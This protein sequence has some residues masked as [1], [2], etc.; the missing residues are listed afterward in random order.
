MEWSSHCCIKTIR[1]MP[2]F[3]EGAFPR[4]GA[5]R[6]RRGR[7]RRLRQ[8]QR[9]HVTEGPLDS[10]PSDSDLDWVI[11][12]NL[13]DNAPFLGNPTSRISEAQRD[14]WQNEPKSIT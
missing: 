2:N 10:P 9:R 13:F 14:S 12:G 1:P 8:R 11:D 5:T 7:R 6:R 4:T 3:R